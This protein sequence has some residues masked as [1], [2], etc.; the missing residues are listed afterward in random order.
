MVQAFDDLVEAFGNWQVD[1]N[2]N[3]AVVKDVDKAID[4]RRDRATSPADSDDTS[5]VTAPSVSSLQA[6]VSYLAGQQSIGKHA[7]IDT[8]CTD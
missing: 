6:K 1:I 4:Q 5:G 2:M 3:K 8:V 7:Y